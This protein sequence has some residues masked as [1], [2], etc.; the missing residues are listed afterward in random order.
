MSDCWAA[1]YDIY[2]HG[3]THYQVNDSLNFVNPESIDKGIQIDNF[4]K[5]YFK[6]I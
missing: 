5:I 4:I 3:Y 1:Y 2:P 6:A